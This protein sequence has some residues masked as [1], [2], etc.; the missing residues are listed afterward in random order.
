VR[1]TYDRGALEIMA[2]MLAHDRDDRFLHRLVIALTEE[3]DLP[4]YC[5]GA[6][7]IRRRLRQRGIEAD[8]TYWIANADRMAGADRL[9]LR[10]HPPPDLVL[11]VDISSSSI[12]HLGVYAA[13]G[14]PEV[15]RLEGNVLTFYVRGR[16]GKYKESP[17]SR[18][19]PFVTPADLLGFLQRARTVGNRTPI[20][21]DF[22]KWVRKRQ[23]AQ[24]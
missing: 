14:V 16:K 24:P 8:E 13:L 2:P 18:S 11:E 12:D 1:L 6:P 3:L 5:G 22:R 10:R 21:R 23:A 19:F 20:V 7:T 17:S 9:D 15:W 4:L